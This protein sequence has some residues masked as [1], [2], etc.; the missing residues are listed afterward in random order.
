MNT[1][2]SRA[3]VRATPESQGIPS[4]AI[5]DFVDAVERAALGLHSFMLLRHGRVVAEGWWEP[6]ARQLPHMLFSLSK[7]F[8]SSAIGMLVAEGKISV[9]DVVLQFFPDEAPALPSANLQAMRVRHLL[10]SMVQRPA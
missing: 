5:G 6:Y 8:T 9:D 4:Q 3:L 2:A 1:T 7:S 10:K